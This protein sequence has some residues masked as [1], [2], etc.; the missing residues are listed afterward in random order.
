MRVVLVYDIADERRLLIVHK[1]CKRYLYWVQNSVFEGELTKGK[2][3][4]LIRE[5]EEVI[6]SEEDSIV[7]Y[8]FKEKNLTGKIQYGPDVPEDRFIL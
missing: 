1:V 6:D 7:I 2:L 5:L 4:Q 3:N 8:T